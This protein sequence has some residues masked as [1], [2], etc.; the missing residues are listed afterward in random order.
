MTRR[1]FLAATAAAPAVLSG[2]R[3]YSW[4]ELE[5]IIARGDVKGKL[6]RADVPTPALMLDLDAFEFNLNKMTT[7]ARDRKRSLRPHGKTH[8]CPEIA[9]RF[10]QAGAAGACAAK[11]SEAEVFAQHGIRGL[12]VTTAV[13]GKYKVERAV[14][15][16]KLAPDTMFVVDNTQNAADLNDA[17]RAAGIKLNLCI[18]LLVGNRTGIKTGEPAAAL[19]ES[20]AKLSHVKFAGL[21]SYCGQASHVKGWEAR[22]KS[23]EDWMGRAVETRRMIE[24]RGIQVGLLTGGS[25]GTY[26]IDTEIDGVT[27]IQP[28]S[29][30]FMDIDYNIIGGKDGGE[31][32]SDFRNSLTVRTTVVSKP[33][34]SYVVVDGGLKAVSTDKPLTPQLARDRSVKYGWGGDEHGKVSLTSALT[35]NVGDKADFIIPHCDPSVNLYDKMFCHRGED[36]EAVWKIAARGMSQ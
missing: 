13:V 36:I 15:L 33:D 29:F 19:A 26:N 21:Q 27:E 12:L 22:R 9:R 4:A 11:L 24:R 7:H 35:L 32:Y 23:S 10:V 3:S 1:T 30:M 20:L 18:D 17:A 28:G 2:A 31:M 14:R 5:K 25:T 16:A 8:K 34:D 6:A